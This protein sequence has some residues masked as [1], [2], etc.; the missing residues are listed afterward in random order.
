[1]LSSLDWYCDPRSED[2]NKT[3]SRLTYKAVVD[4]L[5]V[6]FRRVPV[7]SRLPF[8]T[9]IVRP[10]LAFELFPWLRDARRIAQYFVC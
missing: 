6:E 3:N 10:F 5:V 7:R 8:Y 1:M 4:P 9:R 2:D